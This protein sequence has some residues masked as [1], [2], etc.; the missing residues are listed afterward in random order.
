LNRDNP[1]TRWSK[2]V[3]NND[4]DL[5]MHMKMQRWDMWIC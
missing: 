4:L 1:Q 3:D 5:N 2:K